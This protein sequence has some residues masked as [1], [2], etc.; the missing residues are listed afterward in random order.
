M[1]IAGALAV[2][3][4]AIETL[5]SPENRTGTFAPH[6]FESTY[7]FTDGTTAGKADLCWSDRRTVAASATDT[8]D[9]T[10]GG[11]TSLGA[12]VNFAV[13]TAI[14]VRNR[15]TTSGDVLHVGPAA[16][17]GFLGPWVDAS[18]LNAVSPEGFATFQNDGGWTVTGGST[19]S[20]RIVETGGAN[21]VAYDIFVLGRSA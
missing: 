18:D 19:D 7:G 2:H 1:A 16:A 12:N 9:L 11:L 10:G 15:S 21:A 14:I 5:D 8:I 20:I 6:R 17:D 13:V 3:F 4:R